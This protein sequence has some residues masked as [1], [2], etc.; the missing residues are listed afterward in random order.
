M[1]GVSTIVKDEIHY[2]EMPEMYFEES[3]E[4]MESEVLKLHFLSDSDYSRASNG[5]FKETPI[6]DIRNLYL[7]CRNV[8][9]D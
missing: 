1:T 5:P 4:I 8:K 2:N 3:E 9:K 6:E 7:R